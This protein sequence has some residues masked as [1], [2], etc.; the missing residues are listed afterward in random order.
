MRQ[1]LLFVFAFSLCFSILSSNAA[2]IDLLEIGA[3]PT[4]KSSFYNKP[5]IYEITVRNNQQLD[6]DFI[7][8]TW[9]DKLPWLTLPVMLLHVPANSEKSFALVVF[10]SEE[11]I[12]TF[13]YAVTATSKKFPTISK[14][15][16]F[17]ITVLPPLI[18]KGFS[19]EHV[20]GMIDTEINLLTGREMDISIKYSI[21]DSNGNIIIDDTI[22]EV[23]DGEITI[24]KAFV[25]PDNLLAGE[26]RV[27]VNINNEFLDG[28]GFTI[29][30]IHNIIKNVKRTSSPLYEEV[31][32]TITNKGNT[33]EMNYEVMETTP[34]GV[35]TGFITMPVRCDVMD[36]DRTCTYVIDELAIDESKEIRYRLEFYPT[37]IQIA[38]I[39][40]II[41]AILIFSFRSATKPKLSKKYIKKGRYSHNIVLE[42]KNPFFHN[43]K[44][45]ILRDWVSPLGNVVIEGIEQLSPIIRKSEAGT[46]MI[47]KLGDIRPRE[48]RIITYR[49]KTAVSG[50]LKMPKARIRFKT[51]KGKKWRVTSKNLVIE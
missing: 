46:E 12:D 11:I 44:N 21:E 10:P 34:S 19:G 14:T 22:T 17:S 3:E 39:I 23:V 48:T 24:N 42:I 37:Y 15:T 30:P 35:L 4:E 50:S 7:I 31:I 25:L 43:L 32:V 41:L 40:I 47:W 29:E 13:A 38:A 16:G 27:N 33:V 2:A 36:Q 20:G 6:D 18:F 28:F 49:L 1:F 51:P 45:V 8:T 26:Y 9:G 5:V